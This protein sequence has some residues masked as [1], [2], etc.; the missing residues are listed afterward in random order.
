M[1]DSLI[2]LPA[3]IPSLWRSLH[4]GK[5]RRTANSRNCFANVENLED[6]QLLSAANS[7][8]EHGGVPRIINGTTTTGF[9]AVGMTTFTPT[10]GTATQASGTLIA[11]QWVLTTATASKGLTTAGGTAS[12]V[13][14]GNTYTVDAIT[15]YPKYYAGSVDFRQDIALWHLSTPVTDVTPLTV[16]AT[17]IAASS[18]ATIV[19]FGGTGT[20]TTGTNGTFGTKQTGTTKIERV[21]A[22]QLVWK[23]DGNATTDA[24]FAPNDIGAP[25]LKLVGSSYQ[26][27]GLGSYSSTATGKKGTSVNATRTDIYLGWIDD[28]LDRPHATVTATD[29]YINLPDTVGTG[30]RKFTLTTSSPSASVSAKFHQ[31]GDV[32]VFKVVTAA[33]GYIS[34]GVTNTSPSSNLLDL[35]LELLAA[36]GTTVL[37]TSDDVSQTNLN[38]EFA[39]YLDA[40]SYY[41][42]VSTYADSQKGSYTL[43]VKANYDN[44]S[45]TM[46]SA[47][48]L[49]P[50]SIGAFSTDVFINTTSDVDWFKFKANK[51]GKYQF[52]FVHTNPSSFDPV[53]DVYNSSGT[54]LAHND[55]IGGSGANQLDARVTVL[56]LVSG[57]TYY[58][59][60]SGYVSLVSGLGSTGLGKL[61]G[62]KIG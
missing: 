12:I 44:V 27:Y 60:L 18:T 11:S 5:K 51:S 19:G 40:G 15:I 16:S 62:K 41:V 50:S 26:V 28:V 61:T 38:S 33:N 8:V 29:D 58:L 36:D 45:D 35:K 20:G 6:R 13:L 23:I 25:V 32:D 1:L 10:T 7:V 46:G 17:P 56:G 21:S 49:T 57:Q 34:F 31:Y 39:S 37:F 52:D 22:S 3:A 24:A 54:L 48:S 9:P 14:N 4:A 59:K 2:N 43:T 42:R 53:I 30:N 47:K 55:D